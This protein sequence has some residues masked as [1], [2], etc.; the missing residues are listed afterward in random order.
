VTQFSNE[1]VTANREHFSTI[2]LPSDA[3]PKIENEGRGK[4]F[5]FLKKIFSGSKMQISS[6]GTFAMIALELA[7]HHVLV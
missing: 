7:Y 5:C 4:N 1:I 2:T 3:Q 6:G